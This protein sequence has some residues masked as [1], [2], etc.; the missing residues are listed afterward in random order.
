MA[1]TTWT[2]KQVVD[3]LPDFLAKRSRGF[4]RR[5]EALA[6][7]LG[8]SRLALTTL[9]NGLAIRADDGRVTLERHR[10][11]S[12]YATKDLWSDAW[13]EN[14]AAGVAE[15]AADGWRVT[16]SGEAAAE[17]FNRELRSYL[18]SLSLPPE[19]VERLAAALEA[20]AARIP[21]ASPR[22]AAGRRHPAWR[23][24]PGP[25]I[26]RLNRTV[27]ELWLYRDDSHIAAWQAA[28][29][30]GPALD[31]LS[32]VWEGRTTLGEVSKALEAKQERADVER[33][34][35]EL[36][37]RGAVVRDGERIALT[38]DGRAA[39]DAIERDTDRRYFAQWPSGPDLARIG[40]DLRAVIAALPE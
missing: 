28:G 7:E 26:L 24:E 10:W 23:L 30:A 31:V 27:A 17:R 9:N 15:P 12:P 35:D 1:V 25:P 4:G 38:P 32:Q 16:A 21:A 2:P 19:R 13:R 6:A 40:E 18:A 29:L 33:N 37:R 34:L 11:R 5:I 14:I 8:I 22:V 3:L 39:R 36:V 20:I